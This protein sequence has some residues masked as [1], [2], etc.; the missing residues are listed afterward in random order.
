MTLNAGV[1]SDLLA[2]FYATALEPAVLEPALGCLAHAAGAAAASV[3][4]TG[5]DGRKI[6]WCESAYAPGAI[7]TTGFSMRWTTLF[8][9]AACYLKLLAP[10]SPKTGA[11]ASA[12]ARST[13]NG[14]CR[15]AFGKSQPSLSTARGPRCAACFW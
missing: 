3:I 10:R 8:P 14:R 15:T 6:M 4:D 12:R 2:K 9:H 11:Q 1:V 13:M 5:S 7:A